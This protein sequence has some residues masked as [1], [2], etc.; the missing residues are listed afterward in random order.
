M[1][2]NM[3][4]K[5]P[6]TGALLLTI[7]T[8]MISC[9]KAVPYKEVYKENVETKATL[10]PED[11]YLFV[12]SSDL[13][14]NDD[15]GIS[16]ATPYWQGQ[17]KIVKFRFTENTLQVLQVNE[18]SRLAKDNTLN[19]KILM[20]IPIKNVE[21]RCAEDR[22][23][24]CTNRE[25]ENN[26]KIWSKKGNF[27]PDF[28]S[29]RTTGFNMLPVEMEQLYGSS[30]Y[31][32]TSSRLLNYEL[33]D[34][35]LNIQIEKG[36]RGNAA[37]LG[38][39]MYSINSIDDLQTQIVY[40]YS[41]TK[42]SK[43]ATPGYK[44]IEYPLK[45][46]STFGFFTSENRKYD[47]DMTRTLKNQK[48]WMN[49]WNPE[50]KEI[51]YY[52]SDNFNKPEY[53]SIKKA[54]QIAFD[55]VNEGLK[56]AG[57]KTRLVLNDPAGKK[58]GDTRNSM[59]VM[60]EDPIAGG[61]LGYGPTVA[62]PRT[63]EIMSGR[64]AMYYG[65]F[66][67][68]IR[69]T[70]DE[71]VRELSK[72]PQTEKSDSQSAANSQA[73]QSAPDAGTK[74]RIQ[75]AKYSAY[76]LSTKTGYKVANSYVSS[77]AKS[78]PAMA[79]EVLRTAIKGANSLSK[80]TPK[81][82][83]ETIANSAMGKARFNS[84][85]T[86]MAIADADEGLTQSDSAKAI[87][88][89]SVMSKY[90]NYPSE[91]FPFSE[92]IKNALQAKLGQKL[93]LWNDL[94][95]SEREQVIAIVMP[96]VWVPT[97]V[98]E[99][100]HNLGLRHNFGGSEDRLNFYTEGELAKMGVKHAI[101]YSSVMDYGYSELNLLPTLGKYDIAALRFGYNR[102]V[103]TDKGA[104]VAVPETLEKLTKEKT[105][106]TLRDFTYCSDESV[107]MN[108]GCKR[109]D[110][111]TN[112]T[113]IVQYLIK[114]Y[115]DGYMTRNFRNG[116]E[117]FSKINQGGYYSGTLSR[118]QYIRNFMESYADLKNR[119]G[120]T[121]DSQEM[122]QIPWVK[123]L[124]QAALISGRF[125][126]DVLKTPEVMCAF[127]KSDNPQTIIDI[128]PLRSLSAE[129]TSCADIELKSEFVLV[130]QTGKFFNDV[131]DSKTQTQY[132]DQIDIR[133]IGPDKL[134]AA[135]ALFART[136][137]GTRQNEDN[138]LD[139]KDLA[140]EIATTVTGLLYD[141]T[142]SKLVFRDGM[143]QPV[144][145]IEWSYEMFSTPDS[146]NR[147]SSSHWFEVPLLDSAARR[148]GLPAHKVSFQEQLLKV[149]QGRMSTSQSHSAA[150]KAFVD[151]FRVN[152]IAKVSVVNTDA[153]T[154]AV[155]AGTFKALALPENSI[156]QNA[157]VAMGKSERLSK[158]EAKDL[159]GLLIARS[160]PANMPR[161]TEA[162][163][164]A[165]ETSPEYVDITAND[166][167][168]FKSGAMPSKEKLN[169]L[170]TILPGAEDKR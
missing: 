54:T 146:V 81:Q 164:S 9:T 19:D 85:S 62:N 169:Y 48:E 80:L 158:L 159:E 117:N 110:K 21:Y 35:A 147:G 144:F 7:S 126:M 11:E 140:P 132:A 124:K 3:K 68:G 168:L 156:A 113:E 154:M 24:K 142:M 41:F 22:Y 102:V 92:H 12:A 145:D 43:M 160:R 60:V 170:L 6:V 77:K 111:G 87:D 109:F 100:G 36:F 91:L 66:V 29:M 10:A 106:L 120:L 138:Y 127:A 25:E 37:C 71:V 150:D 46:Q 94:S 72:S 105:D 65:N 128:S 70:Y 73:P 141:Q 2:S 63:G 58:V 75:A 88:A 130:A 122:E 61:P 30:C 5:I 27:I 153:N 137:T 152:R 119:F 57:M 104:T 50:R 32:E 161:S 14:N 15:T 96:E 59:I 44:A 135:Q 99:L 28:N 143:N 114:A 26:E 107:D 83:R 53:A 93:K 167:K 149:I 78:T 139:I 49:R 165:L 166:I 18:E 155:D 136:N 116:R 64:V 31:T 20:E 134:A 163:A 95:D 33:K 129:A 69:Y 148:M 4:R 89:L 90:C 86:L 115:N 23:G 157:M 112:Y 79:P 13:S 133:G 125:F 74:N 16:S 121:D 47:V 56:A 55:R 76:L 8:L 123:D 34:G 84:K 131:R 45:D 1:N 40:H 108:P 151:Q 38:S 97:L 17:E 51:T 39:A 42:L 98:H 103:Q 82:V 52:L 101:P 67:Q 118:F 162:P